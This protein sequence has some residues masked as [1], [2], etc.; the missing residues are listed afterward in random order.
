MSYE[1]C[2]GGPTMIYSH[3]IFAPSSQCK[4]Q[5]IAKE[6]EDMEEHM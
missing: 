6:G 1:L 5:L 2:S 4:L 3:L